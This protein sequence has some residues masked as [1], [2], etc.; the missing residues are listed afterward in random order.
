MK[1][2]A[3]GDGIGS[4]GI[5]YIDDGNFVAVEDARGEGGVGGGVLK[6]VDEVLGL[7]GAGRGD[8][9]DRNVVFDEADEGVLVARILTVGIDAIQHDL[10]GTHLFGE[11]SEVDGV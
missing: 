7:P 10:P 2:E 5:F 3:H 9:G 1:L 4:E 8:D 11:D 6:D